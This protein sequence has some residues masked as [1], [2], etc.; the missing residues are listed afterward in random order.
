MH[1]DAP[2]SKHLSGHLAQGKGVFSVLMK[3]NIVCTNIAHEYIGFWR[4]S[5]RALG[6]DDGTLPKCHAGL[7]PAPTVPSPPAPT[8]PSPPPK[9]ENS[10]LSDGAWG[11]IG[12]VAGAVV[13]AIV[14]GSFTLLAR[15]RAQRQGLQGTYV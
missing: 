6:P 2:T 10:G 14:A 8:E 1:G 5:L 11:A 12:S 4:A 9:K 13:S 7:P 15:K 3:T